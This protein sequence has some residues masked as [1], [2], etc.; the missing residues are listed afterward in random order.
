VTRSL[1]AL[2]LAVTG[3]GCGEQDPGSPLDVE[4]HL[5]DGSVPPEFRAILASDDGDVVAVTCPSVEGGPL[6]CSANGVTV[7]RSALPAVLTLKARGSAFANVRLSEGPEADARHEIELDGLPAFTSV[8]SHA[9]GFSSEQA[10]L[11]FE[12]LSVTAPSELGETRSLKFYIESL[13]DAPRVYFQNTQRFPRHIDFVTMGLGRPMSPAQFEASIRGPERSAMV[14]TLI[15]RPELS[16]DGNAERGELLAP[17]T[18]EFFPSDDLS[19]EQALLAHRLLEER[20]GFLPLEGTERRLTYVPASARA[21]AELVDYVREFRAGEA[22]FAR[23]AELYA[24]VSEQ[25]LNPGLSYGTLRLFS[26]EELEQTVVSR[27]D[28]LVLT[29]LP[30]DLP[31]VA[32]T[33]T[34]ELQTP[35]AH[36]NLAARARGTPNIAL[37]SAS[38]DDRVVPLLDGLVRFEVTADGF[39]LEAASLEEAEEFWASQVRDPLI[40]ASDDEFSG[41]PSFDELAFDDAIRVGVKA[42]NIAELHQLLGE[43]A[44]KG[45]G[46]PFSAFDAF[47]RGNSVEASVCDAAS[48]DCAADGRAAAPCDE[49]MRLCSDAAAAADD[50]Y[51][52]LERLLADERFRGD[53]ATREASLAGFRFMLENGAVDSEFAIALDARVAELFGADS[54]RLRSST[55]VEDLA[56]FSGAGLYD[57][58]SAEAEGDRRASSRIRRVW[59]ST[60]TF[61]A[62]EERAL[63]NVTESAVRMGV[64]VNQAF[65][66]E[67]ANGVLVTQNIAAPSSP[68]YYVNVQVGELPVANPENGAVPEIL[69]LVPVGDDRFETVR[70][71]FSSMSPDAP[72][73]SDEEAAALARAASQVQAHFAPLYETSVQTLAL[74]LEFKFVAPDRALVIKQARPY[75]SASP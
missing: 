6:A 30:N 40:P 74:D 17:V 45:F 52:Y 54:V 72:I 43:G 4:V 23:I 18:L 33:I 28:I 31:L 55:N 42:A 53:T 10:A 35:L 39:T 9:T 26:P 49:A 68:G 12:D 48:A 59:A 67:L 44:P 7:D 15:S 2:V 65:G 36:V 11:A 16:L 37:A 64:A 75:F 62:F 14:G 61:A 66:D 20:L 27:H 29:R 46:V 60:Y 70:Q 22:H 73:L 5:E 56:E 24:G 51:A 32:G 38:T 19:P 25:I 13:N 63:W 69:T 34:E 1:G 21:E 41:L 8:A 71:R 58:V 47:M 3:T 57:S 50:F